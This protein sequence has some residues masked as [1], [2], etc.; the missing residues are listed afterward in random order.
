VDKSL[1]EPNLNS[2]KKPYG[3]VYLRKTTAEKKGK[4]KSFF[5]SKE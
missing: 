5:Q 2:D 1:K 4:V 3:S